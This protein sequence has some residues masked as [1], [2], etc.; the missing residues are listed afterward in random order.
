MIA[1]FRSRF[2]S[3]FRCAQAQTTLCLTAVL[4]LGGFPP[5][6][7]CAADAP[8][9]VAGTMANGTRFNIHVPANWAGVLILNPDLADA[10]DARRRPLFD[11]LHRRG[12]ATATRSRDITLWR[13]RDGST[14]LLQLKTMFVDLFG[15]PKTTI[16]F[17]GSLGG[18]VTRDASETYADAFDG[19]MPTCGGGA[20][21]LAMYNNRFDTTFVLKALLEPDNQALELLN[22]RDDKASAAALKSLLDKALASPQGRARIALAAAISQLQGWPTRAA[23]PPAVDDYELQ[24]KTIADAA[25]GMLTFRKEIEKYAGGNMSWNVGVDYGEMFKLTDARSDRLVRTLYQ[26]AGLDL[27]SDLQTLG[28]APRIAADLQ[29]VAWGRSNGTPTGNL[30]MPTLVLYTAVDPRAPLSEFRAYEETVRRAG[31][32]ALLRQVGVYRS[33]HCAFTGSEQLAGIEALLQRVSSGS[34]PS[35]EVEV[36]NSRASA[37]NAATGGTLEEAKFAE[38]K[39]APQYMRRFT[40]DERVPCAALKQVAAATA[41][42]SP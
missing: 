24:L 33:G 2:A 14:D 19:A 34:W 23:D 3:F 16:V 20:G 13:V 30:K 41:Q 25:A 27:D 22:I 21:T 35:T 12:Y 15:P 39:D 37:L 10:S 1:F 17:G 26:A 38:F 42:C 7:V 18:L 5:T 36:M 9:E 4:L 11:A 28:R 32:L 6:A 29:A 31:K 8:R 40:A